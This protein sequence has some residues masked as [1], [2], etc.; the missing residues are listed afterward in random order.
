MIILTKAS[1]QDLN[2]I[3]IQSQQMEEVVCVKNTINTLDWKCLKHEITGEVLLLFAL[4][5]F[6]ESNIRLYSLV[7]VDAGKY[8]ITITKYMKNI[9]NMYNKIY[10]RIEC[11]VKTSF[12]NGHRLMEMLGFNKECN[13]DYYY[14]FDTYSLY[15]LLCRREL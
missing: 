13:M 14:A 11:T 15:S 10:P 8:A 7:S 12:E 1:M 5:P 3:K 6:S 2:D 9:L 4:V